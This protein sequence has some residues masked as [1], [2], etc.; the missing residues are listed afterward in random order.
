MTGRSVYRHV[1]SLSRYIISSNNKFDPF[2]NAFVLEAAGVL[3]CSCF[4]SKAY[5][6][7]FWRKP[8]NINGLFT[9]RCSQY[10]KRVVDV[11]FNVILILQL[12]GR[13]FV[14]RFNNR[15]MRRVTKKKTPCGMDYTD[16]T[17]FCG[18]LPAFARLL[19]TQG[20]GEKSRVFRTFSFV[21]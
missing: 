4:K 20:R 3:P 6:I 8:C 1:L 2:K 12:I 11:Y 15:A 10:E 21:I 13:V 14:T 16:Y 19:Y 17:L 7:A 9:K 18:T 5:Y